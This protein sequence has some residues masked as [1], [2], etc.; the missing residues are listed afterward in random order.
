M[1]RVRSGLRGLVQGLGL[2]SLRRGCG[3]SVE[4]VFF[5][6][7]GAVHVINRTLRVWLFEHSKVPSTIHSCLGLQLPK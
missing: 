7:F 3:M 6:G 5:L 2:L 4:G 1:F